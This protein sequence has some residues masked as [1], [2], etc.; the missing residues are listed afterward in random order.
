M[1]SRGFSIVEIMVT[2]VLLAVLTSSVIR[3]FDERTRFNN[4]QLL[5]INAELLKQSLDLY[6]R[7]SC[8]NQTSVT[9]TVAS[10]IAGGQLES[11]LIATNPYNDTNL[12]FTVSW[13]QPYSYEI[14]ADMG[15]AAT[16]SAYL[17]SSGATRAVGNLLIWD[18]VIDFGSG[19]YEDTRQ[20]SRMFEGVCN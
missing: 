9:P 1:R 19:A 13:V 17:R 10:L 18:R 5:S 8:N 7:E 15:N 20:F 12:T 3:V 16:A 4:V 14:R 2:I 6:I 11:A